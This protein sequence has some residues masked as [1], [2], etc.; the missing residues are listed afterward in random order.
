MFWA[1]LCLVAGAQA[2][3]QLMRPDIERKVDSVLALMT[4]EEKVGQLNQ[5]TGSFDV[6]GPRP[7]EGSA[8]ERY[9]LVKRGGVGSML[10][11]VGAKATREAQRLAVENSRLGIP[12]IFGYDVIHGYKTIFPVPLAESASWDLEAIETSA[13]IA[14]TEATAAGLHW[15]FAPM[16]DVGRDARWG[17]VMEGAGEDP[18]LGARIAV[19]RIDGFQTNDLANLESMAA[20]AKHFAGYAFAESGREYNTAEISKNTLMNSILFETNRTRN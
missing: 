16:V 1:I 3:S 6:T 7:A 11:V 5:H 19:A 13:R 12:M 9:D 8:A 18:Y 20:T 4:L 10:N 2:Q 14:A 15:T 17:R